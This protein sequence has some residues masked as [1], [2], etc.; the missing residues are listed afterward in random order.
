[1]NV[2]TRR[3]RTAHHAHFRRA[4]RSGLC[5][6]VQARAH[7]RWMGPA[8]FTCPDAEIDFRVGGTYRAMIKSP[9]HGENWFGGVYREIVPDMAARLHFR[10]G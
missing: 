10:L 2:K 8:D 5:A 4:R 6:V 1:M 3:R 9:Q 7:K